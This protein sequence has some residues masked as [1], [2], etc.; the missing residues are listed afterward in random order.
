MDSTHPVVFSSLFFI[1][2]GNTISDFICYSLLFSYSRNVGRRLSGE[3]GAGEGHVCGS[4]AQSFTT[5]TGKLC[6]V[7]KVT[8]SNPIASGFFSG[9]ISF[10]LCK[11][12][13]LHVLNAVKSI[14]NE[15]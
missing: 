4:V 12:L 11:L 9:G 3:G 10:E 15:G 1:S 13:T 2:S 7:V 5:W 8:G 6:E 14:F